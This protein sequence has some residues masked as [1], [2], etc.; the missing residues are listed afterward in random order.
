[1]IDEDRPIWRQL[2]DL[3]RAQI[4]SGELAP[5]AWLPSITYLQQTHD[6]SRTPVRQALAAL[7]ADGLIVY[8]RGHGY[9]VRPPE[10]LEE[11]HPELGS[12]VTARMPTPAERRMYD[13]PEGVPVILVQD[14]DGLVDIYPADQY[15]VRVL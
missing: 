3:L 13:V 4:T 14:P 15:Q 7:R 6:V 10:P 5:G 1:M 2:A 12:L 8:E 11:V 9:R